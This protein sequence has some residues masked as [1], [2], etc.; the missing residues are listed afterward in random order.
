MWEAHVHALVATRLSNAKQGSDTDLIRRVYKQGSDA[1]L[2]C[3]YKEGSDTDLRRV[4]KEGSDT[5][6][7]LLYAQAFLPPSALALYAGTH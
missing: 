2:R 6:L 7:R 3:V 4:Y 1:D 5:D